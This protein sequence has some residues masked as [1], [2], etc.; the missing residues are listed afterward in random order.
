MILAQW[1]QMAIPLIGFPAISVPAGVEGGL[2]VGVQLMGQRFREDRLL[3]AASVLEAH[4]GCI[5]PPGIT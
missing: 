2:P 3:A 1:S 5:A 4:W